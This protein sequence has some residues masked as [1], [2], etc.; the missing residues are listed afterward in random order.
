MFGKKTTADELL[1][2]F[3]A[4][5]DEEKQKFLDSV[6]KGAAP[7][8]EA[9]EEPT[10]ESAPETGETPQ[11]EATAETEETPAEETEEGEGEAENKEET[12]APS[13]E[14]A[15]EH[16]DPT[17]ETPETP[18]ETPIEAHDEQTADNAA[19]V[20]EGLTARI[21]ALEEALKELDGLRELMEKFT[22]AQADKFGYSGTVPGGKKDIGEMSADE[23][24][25]KI[26][27]GQI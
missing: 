6:N 23:M 5:T 7:E 14:D 9:K 21:S 22:K 19:R 11:E 8:T 25:E 2:L 27:S 24:K 18:A 10:P 3:S 4:L 15:Q 17:E 16:P 26:L 12:P 20:M 1:K 13:V